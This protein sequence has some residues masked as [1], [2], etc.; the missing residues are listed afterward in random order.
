[1]R[2]EEEHR[3]PLKPVL[4]RVRGH[5]NGRGAGG[6]TTKVTNAHHEI[7]NRQPLSREAVHGSATRDSLVTSAAAPRAFALMNFAVMA[8]AG[9]RR[10]GLHVS[11]S[12]SD[13][14]VS[15]SV[16]GPSTVF[17]S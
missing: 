1:M 7:G 9:G 14:S 10:R 2:R 4:S 3:V 8:P 6:A 17:S 12:V 11:V 5:A 16:R 13:M 15:V